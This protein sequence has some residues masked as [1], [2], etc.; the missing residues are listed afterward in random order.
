MNRVATW[1]EQ[2][3]T[4]RS[5]WQFVLLPV[6]WLFALAATLRR[7]AYRRGWLNSEKLPLPVIIVGNITVGGSGKTPLVI[8]LVEQLRA[9]GYVP[10]VISR[11][12]GGKE[13]SPFEVGPLSD[14]VDVGDEPVLIA[15]RT[16]APLF[17]GRDRV[18]A[19]K[20]LL[21]SHPNCDVIISDD[22]LQ[23]YR[24]QRDVEIVVV[25]G[26]SGFGNAR[27]LPAGPLR[28]PLR[29][30]QQVDFVVS[31]G[32]ERDPAATSMPLASAA[33]MP[34]EA[35]S[36]GWP[37]AMRLSGQVFYNAKDPNQRAL[38]ADM[39]E[40][41]IHAVAGIGKPL[42]FFD[43]LRG[44]GLKIIEHPFPDHHA[45]RRADFDFARDA[46]VLMTEKDAVK[47]RAFA[48]ESWWVLAV[49]AEL[50]ERFIRQILKKLRPT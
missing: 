9:A 29:R 40:S 6:S 35:L 50:D 4:R 30:L 45:F 20:A 48:Q 34:G 11:G 31:N 8:A 32:V 41:P 18:A 33:W 37:W 14:P 42:R 15:A 2:Q 10:G 24:L 13:R 38:A 16:E 22:G 44:L 26:P 43:Q 7:I 21:E 23:H 39:R 49:S 27:L 25:D 28:E 1:F 5:Y 12:Y 47:C 3:W 36:T 46:I 17:V 19:A